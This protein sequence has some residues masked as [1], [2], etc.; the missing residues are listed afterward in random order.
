MLSTLLSQPCELTNPTSGT[1]G[2]GDA[3]ATW[4]SS[5]TWTGLSRLQLSSGYERTDQRDVSIG[6]W[7]LF[8]PPDAP[9]TERSRVRVDGKDFVVTI[10]YP[11]HSPRAGLHHFECTVETYSG[12]VPNRG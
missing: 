8:L 3:R 11:V 6:Q 9:V 1:D 2:F 5:P 12:E 7:K 4:P 10:V